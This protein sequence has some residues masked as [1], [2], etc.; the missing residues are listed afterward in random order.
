[1]WGGKG[2]GQT[3]AHILTVED[4]LVILSNVASS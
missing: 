3:K 1:M 2:F 4:Q